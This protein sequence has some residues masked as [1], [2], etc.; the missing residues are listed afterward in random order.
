MHECYD[1]KALDVAERLSRTWLW[2]AFTSTVMEFGLG[3]VLPSSVLKSAWSCIMHFF[4]SMAVD[5]LRAGPLSFMPLYLLQ[6]LIE[7]LSTGAAA[8]L[9]ASGLGR[10]QERTPVELDLSA[11]SP[12]FCSTRSFIHGTLSAWRVRLGDGLRGQ[13]ISR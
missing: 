9:G 7:G 8:P 3:D 12:S 10:A 1:H 4:S 6:R 2:S 5:H 11:L 13:I